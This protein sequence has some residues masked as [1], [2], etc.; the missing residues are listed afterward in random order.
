[1]N[2]TLSINTH[3]LCLTLRHQCQQATF[4]LE[5][6]NLSSPPATA[7]CKRLTIPHG[8][9]YA[10]MYSTM[11]NIRVFMLSHASSIPN[12]QSWRSDGPLALSHRNLPGKPWLTCACTPA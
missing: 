3:S 7:V 9:L 6:N 10:T 1:M 8:P 12:S 2:A 4:E 5:P 11:L